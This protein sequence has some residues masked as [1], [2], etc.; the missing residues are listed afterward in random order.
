[1]WAGCHAENKL[2]SVRQRQRRIEED[3]EIITRF[4]V[5]PS[6]SVSVMSM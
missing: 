4:N 2:G 6:P 5:G 1:M 3:T